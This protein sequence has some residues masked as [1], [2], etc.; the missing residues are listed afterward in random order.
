MVEMAMPRLDEVEQ[1]RLRLAA[2]AGLEQLI[3]ARG[4]FATHAE[5]V[6]FQ[7]EGR[8]FGLI[9]YSRGIRNPAELDATLSVVSSSNGPY[10]DHIGDDGI[11]RY[12]PRKGDASSGDNKKL[13]IAM[14]LGTPIVLFQKP[15]PNV[16][17][18]IVPAFVIG[19]DADRGFF[20]IATDES[21]WRS[22][23]SALSTPIDKAYV[24]QIVRRRVH[25]PVFRARVIVAYAKTC[26]IC[27]LKHPELLDAAH[28][29]PD[30]D[31]DGVAEVTNGLALCKI[32]HAAYDRGLL[33]ISPDYR[34]HV[35][36]RLLRETDGPMLKHGIQEMNGV[37]LTLP[38]KPFN[39]PSKESLDRRFQLYLSEGTSAQGPVEQGRR[40]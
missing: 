39:W 36:S 19:E 28:I 22:H 32:H 33:G 29:I 3:D 2:F 31:K 20:L 24:A 15:L 4:G 13:R 10:S 25:Q 16:Y 37:T 12:S 11:Y 30:S 14:A 38:P 34:V 27:R 23:E 40:S 18:P 1:A 21:A 26:A 17:V 5:L 35:G 8:Q 7:L 9:D 6:Y